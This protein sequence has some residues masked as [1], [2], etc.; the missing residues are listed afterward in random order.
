MRENPE[1][2][3]MGTARQPFSDRPPVVSLLKASLR[4]ISGTRMSGLRRFWD[5]KRTA[6]KVREV[7]LIPGLGIKLSTIILAGPTVLSAVGARP[8]HDGVRRRWRINV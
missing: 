5:V 3:L 4:R 7:S 8:P 1:P 6:R 2:S